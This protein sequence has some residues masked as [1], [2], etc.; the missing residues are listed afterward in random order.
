MKKESYEEHEEAIKLIVEE[1]IDNNINSS[2]PYEEWANGDVVILSK[3]DLGRRIILDNWDI[4]DEYFH[5]V[6][7]D[8]LYDLVEEYINDVVCGILNGALEYCDDNDINYHM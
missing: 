5:G 2:N 4:D 6:D 8:R 1:Y 3:Y 7:Y